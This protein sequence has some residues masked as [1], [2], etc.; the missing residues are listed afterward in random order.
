MATVRIMPPGSLLQKSYSLQDGKRPRIESEG[1]RRHHRL[2][3]GL[4]LPLGK[5]FWI[6]SDFVEA[7]RAM[8]QTCVARDWDHRRD[9]LR[10]CL[11]LVWVTA[12]DE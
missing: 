1:V 12:G 2:E 4:T 5:R 10:G 9:H 7:F 3:S 11:P 8:L 6:D